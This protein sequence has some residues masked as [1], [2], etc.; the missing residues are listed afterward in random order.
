M[1]EDFFS[2]KRKVRGGGG[3]RVKE[4]CV[5]ITVRALSNKHSF[6]IT[7]TIETDFNKFPIHHKLINFR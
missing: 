5:L 1:L 4:S 3:V 7:V 2:V 6:G